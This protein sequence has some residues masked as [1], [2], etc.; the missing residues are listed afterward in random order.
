MTTAL[1]DQ[2]IETLGVK[3]TIDPAT[4]IRTR[5]DFLKDFARGT[6]AR[7]FVLGISGGQDST[8]AGKLAQIAVNELNDEIDGVDFTFLPVFLPHGVQADAADAKLAVDFFEATQTPIEFNIAEPVAAFKT[9]YDTHVD[10]L[11]AE[12]SDYAKGNVKARLRAVTQYALASEL[13]LLVIGTDHAAEA[14]T[15]FFTKF[16]DGAADILPLSG[17]S[18]RQGKA[19]LQELDAPEVFYTKKPTADLLDAVVGQPDET[20]LGITY[21]QLDDYLEGQDVPTAVADLIEG[22]Y[23]MTEHKRQQPVTPFDTW[24]KN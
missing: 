8:L 7:G 19:L 22:R 18:K 14:V 11:G 20:E 17:L 2:I 4:E 3:S 23:L 6:G 5:V 9:Q 12:L 1:Q 16:G 10:V 13:K 15:G 24:W 21:D